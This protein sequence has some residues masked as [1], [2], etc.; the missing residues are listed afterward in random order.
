[1]AN[2]SIKVNVPGRIFHRRIASLINTGALARWKDALCLGELFQQFFEIRW[3]PLKRLTPRSALLQRAEAPILMRTYGR[4]C[5]VFGLALLLLFCRSRH[6]RGI[7]SFRNCIFR[8]PRS[9]GA[10]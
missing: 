5:H 3:K 10:G 8:E 1:M 6:W 2:E 7:D 4:A 9:P